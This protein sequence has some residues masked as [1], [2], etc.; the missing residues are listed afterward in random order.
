MITLPMILAEPA[1]RSIEAERLPLASK[2]PDSWAAQALSDVNGLLDDHAHLER[3]AA[4][5]ALELM[6][7]WPTPEPPPNWTVVLAAIAKDEAAHLHKVARLLM[8]R[9]QQMSRGHQNAYARGL[10]NLVRLGQGSDE[11]VDRLM[12]AALIELRSCERFD[13]L[14]RNC[15]DPQLVQLYRGLWGSEHNHFKVFLKLARHFDPARKVQERWAVML[16]AEAEILAQQAPGA[17][18]HSGP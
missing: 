13:V 16:Q 7:R 6:T 15:S 12:I 9:G 2:T 8:Q 3:K 4:T 17:R 5:N 11:L 10:R 1:V 18:I 14:A